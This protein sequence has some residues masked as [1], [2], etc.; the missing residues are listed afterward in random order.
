M[1]FFNIVVFFTNTPSKNNKRYG[2]PKHELLSEPIY[3][4]IF[5]VIVMDI[6]K[7]TYK[8]HYIV[9]VTSLQNSTIYELKIYNLIGLE[10]FITRP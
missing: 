3:D 7:H 8:D 2:V 5:H 9:F 1:I 10:N 4:S 6:K